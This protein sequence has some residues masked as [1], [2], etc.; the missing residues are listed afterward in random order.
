MSV[1]LLTSKKGQKKFFLNDQLS[2][3][4]RFMYTR[5]IFNKIIVKR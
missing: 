1:K 4:E 2:K 3:T 5:F